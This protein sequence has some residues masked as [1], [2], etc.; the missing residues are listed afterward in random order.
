[1][2]AKNIIFT[3]AVG[4][5]CF[6]GGLFTSKPMINNK[7]TIENE[8]V[9]IEYIRVNNEV[10]DILV[11]PKNNMNLSPEFDLRSENNYKDAYLVG[12]SKEKA[13]QL[14][15]SRTEPVEFNWNK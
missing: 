2:K 4:A 13:K 10:F 6:T 11:T 8:Q 14:N 9:S 1:M 7:Q 3:L 12:L 5:I 15:D